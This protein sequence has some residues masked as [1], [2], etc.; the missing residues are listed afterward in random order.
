TFIKKAMMLILDEPYDQKIIVKV[1][2]VLTYLSSGRGARGIGF[3]GELLGI[4][5]DR[6]LGKYFCN[7][8]T[9]CKHV[10]SILENDGRTAS[11]LFDFDKHKHWARAWS[12]VE[13]TFLRFVVLSLSKKMSVSDKCYEEMKCSFGSL[14]K[15][16]R[17]ME[18]GTSPCDAF[19]D[20]SD[21]GYYEEFCV[22]FSCV[23][24]GLQLN[25]DKI[26]REVN[27]AITLLQNEQEVSYFG[28]LVDVDISPDWDKVELTE[29]EKKIIAKALDHPS[30]IIAKTAAEIIATGAGGNETTEEVKEILRTGRD[31]ALLLISEIA[32]QVW[33]EKAP[34]I[35]LHRLAGELTDGCQY[36]L[37]KLPNLSN[38]Q[39]DDRISTTLLKELTHPNVEVAIGA[40]KGYANH[41][42]AQAHINEL[43]DALAYWKEN[44]EPYPVET[45]TVPPSPREILV[46]IVDQLNGFTL[47]EL[48][49]LC[50]DPRTDVKDVVRDALLRLCKSDPSALNKVINLIQ[51]EQAPITLLT[52]LI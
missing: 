40:A 15:I 38:E 2:N 46:Q 31:T 22:V 28:R 42:P 12:E 17:V 47:S 9:I 20:L 24:S 10:R 48:A 49:E 21:Q 45:G 13:I 11:M 39:Y 37:E 4:V 16:S 33:G 14:S 1:A 23:I 52:K 29:T 26:V 44:E 5:R 36:L 25:P 32:V 27:A 6:K 30:E 8:K 7:V 18:I 50:G 43:K 19:M 3:L 41:H 35:I 51:Q 34:G